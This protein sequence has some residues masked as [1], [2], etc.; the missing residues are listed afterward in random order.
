[1][2][3]N[4]QKNTPPRL[5]KGQEK[6]GDRLRRIRKEKGF[7]QER[8][9]DL[10]GTT[11]IMIS[12]YERGRLRINAELAVAIAQAMEVTTDELLGCENED[13]PGQSLY[14]RF[15]KIESMPLQQQ[16]VILDTMDT[17]IR[18]LVK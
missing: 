16:K 5:D 8:L 7:T 2:A 3:K 10:V 17:F 12:D 18:G 15:K 6:L 1:M 9:A 4:K 14:R 11:N 13:K